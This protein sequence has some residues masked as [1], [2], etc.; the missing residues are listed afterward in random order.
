MTDIFRSEPEGDILL[1]VPPFTVANRPGLGVHTLQACAREAGFKVNVLYANLSFAAEIGVANYKA[2]T[3]A[4]H[5]LL[6][7]ERIFATWAYDGVPALGRD[8]ETFL[9]NHTLPDEMPKT[10]DPRWH[11]KEIIKTSAT[12]LRQ[13]AMSAGDWVE[14]VARAISEKKFKIVGCT[15]MFDQTAAG[16]AILRRVKAY[17]PDVL[18]LMGGANCEGEMAEGMASLTDCL[19][20]IFS[21]ESEETFVNFLR[22]IDAGER[23]AEK[24]IRGQPQNNMNSLPVPDFSEYYEQFDAFLPGATNEFGGLQIM[25]ETSRGCWWGQ[26]HHCTFCGLNGMGM[27]FREKSAEKVTAELRH[28]LDRHPKQP[29]TRIMMA[30]NIMPYTFFKTVVPEL[31]QLTREKTGLTIF[32]EQK[33]NLNLKQVIALMEAN[34]NSI[35]PGI[36][37]IS[38]TLLRIMD[39]GIS[40]AQNIAMMRY[41]RSAGMS[42]LWS[43]LAGFPGE[44]REAYE[45]TLRL[46]PL[47]RHLE[48]PSGMHYLTL[49]RFSPYYERPE[50]YQIENIRP[51]DCY[52]MV[53]PEGADV[54]K[55]AYHFNGDFDSYSRQHTDLVTQ[56]RTEVGKWRAA[57]EVYAPTTAG[58]WVKKR[59]VLSV[60]KR[61]NGSYLLQDSRG[62][63]DTQEERSLSHA[64]AMA[65]LVQQPYPPLLVPAEVEWA[66]ENKI[67]V[68]VDKHYY[69]PLATMQPAS[70]LE[71]ESE[72][73]AQSKRRVPAAAP[74][75]VIPIANLEIAA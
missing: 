60:K 69:V 57:W 17:R 66:I 71:F 61:G 9:Q 65:A 16:I 6:V 48:P 35:Q 21:G 41:A 70:L 14:R 34:I 47:L 7:G 28:L 3:M 63:P 64:Q 37:A 36:E 11:R 51:W 26:K 73:L 13:I 24:I 59:P 18:A 72:A 31:S 56:I 2:M 38:S 49:D 30:D 52:S 15:S 40:A 54:S 4:R 43:L 20:Y 74:A 23:P 42:L 10:P 45:E 29:H 53:L 25:Y 19:D 46:V 55:V 8:A 75:G 32:Y 67:G 44:D 50:D 58:I 27:G 68:V 5:D 62:L 12:H 33:A 22:A 1:V 39:K